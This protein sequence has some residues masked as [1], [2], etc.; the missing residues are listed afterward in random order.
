M[1]ITWFK[2]IKNQLFKKIIIFYSLTTI[3]FLTALSSLATYIIH[4]NRTKQVINSNTRLMDEMNYTLNTKYSNAQNIL[5]NLLGNRS[6]KDSIFAFLNMGFPDFYTYSLDSYLDR[7]VSL[8]T[9][10]KDY[11]T[12][13]FLQDRDINSLV[14]YS[15]TEGFIYSFDK[16]AKMKY[17]S[18]YTSAFQNYESKLNDYSGTNKPIFTT[19]LALDDDLSN[20]FSIIVTIK[21]D[22]SLKPIG[23]LI[24]NYSNSSIRNAY[25]FFL[26][27]S[28]TVDPGHVVIMTTD[29]HVVFQS[30][31]HYQHD[32]D[33]T[34]ANTTYDYTELDKTTYVKSLKHNESN[35]IILGLIPKSI[36]GNDVRQTI[37]LIVFVT[38]I[39]ILAI[40]GLSILFTASYSSRLHNIT[41]A[42]KK[43]RKGDLSVRIQT[44]NKKDELTEI[45]NNF[46]R[47]CDDLDD[48]IEKVYVY[49][50]KQKSAELKSLQAQINPHF[51]YN[52]LESIRMRAAVRGAL[53]VSEM[54]YI[55]ATFFRNSLKTETITTIEK[56]I[57][58]CKLYL[59]LFQIRYNDKLSVTFNI[60]EAML[61]YSIVSLSLQPI[62]ENYI[63]H[64]IDLNATNNTITI[65]G[66]FDHDDI[67]IEIEDNGC[68]IEAH[69]LMDINSALNNKIEP[70]SIG[71]F[72]VHERLRIVYGDA[73]GLNITSKENI[74]TKVTIRIPARKKGDL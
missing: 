26:Q 12:T 19:D 39:C 5:P 21:N 28:S 4:D 61:S 2:N 70:Y 29:N 17:H 6:Y 66:R 30:T 60:E 36:I 38:C 20:S 25:N 7:N 45:A 43:V 31:T 68:G 46:N 1:M 32:I 33:P 55:L 34:L 15:P 63:V 3:I 57:D 72:N 11:M 56:E 64:G 18:S 13:T 41:S 50:V 49:Q 53:D 69:R 74:G 23:K 48:Y 73:Y 65:S 40:I 10:L 22:I 27:K 62:I 24:I 37:L 52:T 71:I 58:H 67:F 47:M 16:N 44:K 59:K 14:F 8:F 54:I 35:M 42:I 51:L 9:R